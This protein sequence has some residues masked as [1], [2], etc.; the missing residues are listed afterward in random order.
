MPRTRPPERAGLRAPELAALV[1]ETD[2]LPERGWCAGAVVAAGRGPHLAVEHATGYALRYR[3]YDPEAGR[4]VLLPRAEQVPAAPG[5]LFDLASLTKLFTAVAVLQQTERGTLRLD[6]PAARHVPEFGAA[7]KE[8]LTLRQLLT[9]TSGL[10]PELPLHAHPEDPLAP[11]WAAEPGP[12]VE[13]YSDLGP[14]ALQQ[15][16]ERA[17]GTGLDTL[18][19][20]G[21]TAPLGMDDTRYGPVPAE[22]AAATEDQ[23]RPWAKADRGLLRGTVHDE[24]AWAL[25]GV[26]G[27]AGLFSTAFDLT[28]L[29]RALLDD[30]AGIL[31][32]ASVRQLLDPPGTGFTTGRPWFMGELGATAAG[33][34]GFTGTSLVLDP[35]TGAFLVL[36]AN[37]VH[38]VRR[39]PDSAPRAALATLLARAAR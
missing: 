7:G 9:H 20:E 38:P 39:P 34:T 26:A 19:R 2:A 6:D 36:L 23:R 21:I 14:I 22:R 5:T 12:P 11:L 29:C 18:V 4:G 17:T 15:V 25:G 28:L 33:H 13:R 3:A 37:T 8:R 10:P 31:T 27:H 1:A 24:N 32:P 35:A 30:G 16:L